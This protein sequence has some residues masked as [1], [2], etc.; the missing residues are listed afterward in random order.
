MLIY[1]GNFV[2]VIIGS[3]L[4]GSSSVVIKYSSPSFGSLPTS[5]SRTP[6]ITTS[7]PSYP[8]FIARYLPLT[9]IVFSGI[10]FPPPPV[11]LRIASPISPGVHV[12]VLFNLTRIASATSLKTLRSQNTFAISSNFHPHPDNRRLRCNPQA[13]VWG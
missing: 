5:E 6:A 10:R 2:F 1:E 4:G 12:F 7:Y 11:I 8:S 13:S 3:G 9:E